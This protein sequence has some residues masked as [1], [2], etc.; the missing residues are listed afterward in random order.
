[1]NCIEFRRL[2]LADPSRPASEVVAHA[3]ECA[4][5][6][7]FLLR[8]LE[9]E[10][11]LAAALRVG[12]PD[13]LADRLLASASATRWSL[14]WLALAASLLAV[15]A[16]GLLLGVPRSD[17]LALAGIDFVVF[18]EA[19]S[20]VVAKPTDMQ[21]LAGVARKMGVSLPH[22]LG[23]IHYVCI[24]PFA[25]GRAHH[26]LVN[27]PLGKVT[28]LLIPERQLVSRAVATTRGL[29]AVVVPAAAGSIAI[30]GDSSRSILRVETLLRSS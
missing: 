10:A 9:A 4:A 30:I 28:L 27:T 5:C 22:E 1:M 16:L 20:I 19:Q 18:E 17:P 24:Y 21:V 14:R 26:A 6:K 7:D 3:E 29:E 25:G 11:A 8:S 2:V 23:Q 15:L 13:G 12:V